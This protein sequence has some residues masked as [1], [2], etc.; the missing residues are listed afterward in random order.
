MSAENEAI[1]RRGWE[2]MVNSGNLDLVDEIYASD[3]AYHGPDGDLSG[4]AAIRE[5]VTGYLTALPDV[6]ATVDQIVASGDE[7]FA[8]IS[9]R[10]TQTGPLGDFPPSG[11][12]VEMTL[13][14]FVCIEDG[15]IAEEWEQFDMLG[16]LQQIGAIPSEVGA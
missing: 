6:Q 16:M 2:E 10:G 7:V 8:R 13:L 1:V 3:A 14:Q 9:V 5:M 11:K 4:P 12:P 15:R